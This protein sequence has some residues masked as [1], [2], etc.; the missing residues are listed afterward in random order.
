VIQEAELHL[1]TGKMPA[2]KILAISAEELE[3]LRSG[4]QLVER[5]AYYTAP[6]LKVGAM[7]E[8]RLKADELWSAVEFD[9]TIGYARLLCAVLQ[10]ADVDRMLSLHATLHLSCVIRFATLEVT[11]KWHTESYL[12]HMKTYLEL[13]KDLRQPF[14]PNHHFSL[15]IP[16][17]LMHFGPMRGWWMFPFERLIYSLQKVR[18]N[19]HDG[20]T[21]ITIM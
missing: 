13:L 1:G 15:H 20:E 21:E 5:P 17:M 19:N 3:M 2:P 16:E 10:E 9:Y 12:R 14:V 6:P 11:S 4:A 18:K 8:G 7:S